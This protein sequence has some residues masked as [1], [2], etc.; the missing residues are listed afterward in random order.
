MRHLPRPSGDLSQARPRSESVLISERQFSH[1]FRLMGRSGS[2]LRGSDNLNAPLTRAAPGDRPTIFARGSCREPREFA[3]FPASANERR[4]NCRFILQRTIQVRSAS[5]TDGCPQRRS[6][7]RCHQFESG[8]MPRMKM[9][10]NVV[11]RCRRC[12]NRYIDQK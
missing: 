3:V 12:Q 6:S 2:D 5:L 4:P 8:G 9:P 11:R 7:P 10:P 1:E